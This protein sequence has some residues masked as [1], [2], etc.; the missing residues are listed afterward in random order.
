M[1]IDLHLK[2]EVGDACS[3]VYGL[4]NSVLRGSAYSAGVKVVVMKS[5]RMQNQEFLTKFAA[6][7]AAQL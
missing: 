3:Q 4:L 7:F 6:H 5:G 1:S 2:L